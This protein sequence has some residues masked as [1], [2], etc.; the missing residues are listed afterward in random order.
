VPINDKIKDVRKKIGLTEV[1]PT[2]YKY[3][4][5][6]ECIRGVMEDTEF[7]KNAGINPET[8]ELGEIKTK[9]WAEVN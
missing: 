8:K 9:D 5:V 1:P 3:P 2:T 7:C 4:E 6:L